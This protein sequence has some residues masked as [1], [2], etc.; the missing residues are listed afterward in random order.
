MVNNQQ[1]NSYNPMVNL[2]PMNGNNPMIIPTM[3]GVSPSFGVPPPHIQKRIQEEK[4]KIMQIQLEEKMHEYL[5]K[6]NLPSHRD[7]QE[8]HKNIFFNIFETKKPLDFD[9]IMHQDVWEGCWWYENSETKI[10]IEKIIDII[11]LDKSDKIKNKIIALKKG[12]KK[13]NIIYTIL[14]I[15]YLKNNFPMKLNEY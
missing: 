12:K 13:N 3:I 4:E 6:N 1:M 14:A 11:S 5:M 10:I 7:Y 8:L 2:Q 15:Y 9:L